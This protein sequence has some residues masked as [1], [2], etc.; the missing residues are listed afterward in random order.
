[1]MM[2][3]LSTWLWLAVVGAVGYG[4]FQM[5]YEVMQVED[6][7]GRVNRAIDADR[8]QLRVLN[9]EWSFLNQPARLDQLRQ[10]FLA[11]LRPITRLELG[12]LDQVPFRAGEGPAQPGTPA[13]SAAQPAGAASAQPSHEAQLASA[14]PGV[15]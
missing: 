4:M 2:L 7:L 1:M 11:S 6:Q 8:D 15:R 9:A 13:P 12:S 14:K 5:K 3:R 10:R